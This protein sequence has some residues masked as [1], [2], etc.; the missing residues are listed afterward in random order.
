MAQLCER[1]AGAPSLRLLALQCD[2][3]L[4]VLALEGITALAESV[5]LNA[6]ALRARPIRTP[7]AQLGARNHTATQCARA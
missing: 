4:L 6:T 5:G 1:L 3:Q 2:A 7:C